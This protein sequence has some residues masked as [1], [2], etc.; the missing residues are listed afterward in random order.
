MKRALSILL[1]MSIFCMATAADWSKY[2]GVFIF[3]RVESQSVYNGNK[4]VVDF[5]ATKER[6]QDNPYCRIEIGNNWVGVPNYVYSIVGSKVKPDGTVILKLKDDSWS[7][8]ATMEIH[9]NKTI[10]FYGTEEGKIAH[11]TWYTKL[12]S[13]KKK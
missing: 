7:I 9:P 13:F 5:D 3:N 8:T 1:C 12:H 6:Y 2:R 11:S 4:R 10:N